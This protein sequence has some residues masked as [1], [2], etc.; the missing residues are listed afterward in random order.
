MDVVIE[1]K[2]MA[3]DL[4]GQGNTMQ[5]RGAKNY[6]PFSSLALE[7]SANMNVVPRGNLSHLGPDDSLFTS[8]SGDLAKLRKHLK[9]QP[10]SSWKNFARTES[11]QEK[12]LALHDDVVSFLQYTLHYT[13]HCVPP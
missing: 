2:E 10:T 7:D 12:D 13:V 4:A 8:D 9:M 3:V 6:S 5:N 11:I 1:G